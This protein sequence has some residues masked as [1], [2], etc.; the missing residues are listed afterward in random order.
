MKQERISVD[1]V[2]NYLFERLGGGCPASNSPGN[3]YTSVD[4]T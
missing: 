4:V 2:K 3:Y 1:K